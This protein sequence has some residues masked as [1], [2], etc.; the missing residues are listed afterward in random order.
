VTEQIR[1]FHR[2][3]DVDLALEATK[4]GN[5]TG[6]N[7]NEAPIGTF[8]AIYEEK[9]GSEVYGRDLWK[10][11]IEEKD[12]KKTWFSELINRVYNQK[13]EGSCVANACAGM[14][15]DCQAL[16][17][18][19]DSVIHLSAM[20]L[21]H[22]TGS[23]PNSGSTLDGNLNRIMKYGVLPSNAYPENVSRFKH[24]HVDVG[25]YTKLADGWEET[26]EMFKGHEFLDISTSEGFA[27]CLLK[28]YPVM[29]ARSGH[30]IRAV[31]LFY[32]GGKFLLGY[33]NSWGQWGDVLNDLFSYGMG[34]DSERVMQG[35]ASGAVCLR[36]VNSP[37]LNESKAPAAKPRRR[38]AA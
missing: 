16:Q 29:Y 14:H 34:Y 31:R 2:W 11:M 33:L 20:S 10:Q 17:F 28:G 21:Y 19:V 12:A 35:A 22:F 18:G 5:F 3:L 25:F 32:K 27:T 23:R 36:S 38:R 9:Y 37:Q 6:C 13:N 24:C 26:A 1:N 4:T 15:E 30:C 8:R 7:P